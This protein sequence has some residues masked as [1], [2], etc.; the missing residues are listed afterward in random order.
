[1]VAA[2]APSL[3]GLTKS[4]F[5]EMAE[6]R[7]STPAPDGAQQSTRGALYNSILIGQSGPASPM[8]EGVSPYSE[9]LFDVDEVL[10]TS[11]GGK[12]IEPAT[13][14][15]G[16]KR[17]YE[18]DVGGT[19]Y[20]VPTPKRGSLQGSPDGRDAFVGLERHGTTHF[21]FP[22]VHTE[23]MAIRPPSRGPPSRP[24]RPNT[25]LSGQTRRISFTTP[26]FGGRPGSSLGN[27][28]LECAAAG[29]AGARADTSPFVTKGGRARSA[30][31]FITIKPAP[32]ALDTLQKI[33]IMVN[34]SPPAAP[35]ME[36]PRGRPKG[37]ATAGR[38][39][40]RA[41]SS[42]APSPAPS[43]AREGMTLVCL[44]G[45]PSSRP[46]SVTP[47]N[48]PSPAVYAAPV[49]DSRVVMRRVGATPSPAPEMP[50]PAPRG[51][52]GLSSLFAPPPPLVTATINRASPAPAV[53][54]EPSTVAALATARP[55][56]RGAVQCS[57]G[58]GLLSGALSPTTTPSVAGGGA[59]TT[60][61]VAGG[62]GT[63]SLAIVAST[64]SP[65]GE[66]LAAAGGAVTPTDAKR[67][68]GGINFTFK[69]KPAATV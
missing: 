35:A 26:P 69:P 28:S 63:C 6:W 47:A 22:D 58:S 5:A 53:K 27:M 48:A 43:N 18:T 17:Q 50:P 19:R 4:A 25:S 12:H 11:N 29:S 15:R 23:G 34:R 2:G 1:M 55:A 65:T 41:S 36:K 42:A 45:R 7:G 33:N 24:S 62:G 68:G 40:S 52:D 13:A 66:L 14:R 46:S 59:T 44:S 10:A 30:S 8:R 67:K 54:A 9:L 56:S 31:P 20:I 3:T 38:A 39:A 61:G 21:P 32:Q 60:G 64:A 16:R 51:H 49:T 57:F 37:S